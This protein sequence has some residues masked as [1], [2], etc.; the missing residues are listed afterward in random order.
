MLRCLADISA[1]L[2]ARCL[3]DVHFF[4]GKIFERHDKM[5]VRHSVFSGRHDKMSGKHVKMSGRN[6]KISGRYVGLVFQA[7]CLSLWGNLAFFQSGCQERHFNDV[8][9]RD[10]WPQTLNKC[11][12]KQLKVFCCVIFSATVMSNRKH[13]LRSPGSCLK[14]EMLFFSFFRVLSDLQEVG[15]NKFACEK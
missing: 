10:T 2:Q 12:V 13:I 14:Q 6:V 15:W 5:P 1:F 8:W 4:Q 3:G 7:R 9:R 11:L